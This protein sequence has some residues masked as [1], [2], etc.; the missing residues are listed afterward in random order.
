MD[1]DNCLLGLPPSQQILEKHCK[2]I[3]DAFANLSVTSSP[4]SPSD[5]K[6][7]KLILRIMQWSEIDDNAAIADEVRQFAYRLLTNLQIGVGDV[8]LCRIPRRTTVTHS[9]SS[10]T[11][12]STDDHDE[13]ESDHGASPPAAP[14]LA[15]ASAK[16]NSANNP[17]DWMYCRVYRVL[18][19]SVVVHNNPLE[20]KTLGVSSANVIPMDASMRAALSNVH[21]MQGL[22]QQPFD[23]LILEIKD[24]IASTFTTSMIEIGVQPD[25]FHPDKE[26]GLS[27]LSALKESWT[28]M[29][30][31]LETSSLQLLQNFENSANREIKE[32]IA[33]L[34]PSKVFSPMREQ[35]FRTLRDLPVHELAQE[36]IAKI[37]G[38]GSEKIKKLSLRRA[39]ILDGSRKKALTEW[40]LNHIE[41]SVDKWLKDRAFDFEAIPPNYLEHPPRGGHL[42]GVRDNLEIIEN[43]KTM[44]HEKLNPLELMESLKTE[45]YDQ[46]NPFVSDIFAV[47]SDAFHTPVNEETFP[48]IFKQLQDGVIDISQIEEG[49]RIN[50]CCKDLDYILEM[51]QS[52]EFTFTKK[53]LTLSKVVPITGL[54]FSRFLRIENELRTVL[55][56]WSH[57]DRMTPAES[58]QAGFNSIHSAYGLRSL[59]TKREVEEHAEDDVR[60]TNSTDEKKERHSV[61]GLLSRIKRTER[62][63]STLTKGKDV[64]KSTEPPNFPPAPPP[65]VE[66]VGGAPGQGL[67]SFLNEED[68]N[69]PDPSQLSS[70]SSGAS[71]STPLHETSDSPDTGDYSPPIEPPSD[72]SSPV[73]TKEVPDVASGETPSPLVL[74]RRPPR[75]PTVARPARSTT[76]NAARGRPIPG[77]RSSSVS[78]ISV[79]GAL[80]PSVVAP[81]F[82]SSP[83][84][85]SSAPSSSFPYSPPPYSAPSSPFDTSPPPDPFA[86]DQ[87]T[88]PEPL[89]ISVHPPKH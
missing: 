46:I 11:S 17:S 14:M 36:Y 73:L 83:S 70:F 8:V 4:L 34:N 50:E 56:V 40:Y 25:L 15:A 3:T 31:F 62:K 82:P 58:A 68:L 53:K 78:S 12:S 41:N 66:I 18:P 33:K 37:R 23:L 74:G 24:H 9:S 55:D 71:S 19:N 51:K 72:S 22:V 77:Q 13:G 35:I 44:Q 7:E 28:K 79:S 27:D 49:D 26:F 59:P 10:S 21:D 38:I 75:A 1:P 87:G 43:V 60:R 39:E 48:E 45:V 47:V 52:E 76:L 89:S 54:I 2:R 57:L 86:S 6:A 32:F 20:S 30:S 80:P 29:I 42:N 64:V 61:H 81:N 65:P 84:A 88:A 63:S 67:F 16:L 85:S 5:L 69:T